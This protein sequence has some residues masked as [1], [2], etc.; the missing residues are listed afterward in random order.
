MTVLF[1]ED[2]HWADHATLDLVK[3]LVRRTIDRRTL[4]IFTLRDDE[5][6][7]VHPLR[8]VL[9]DLAGQR[10]V[11]RLKPAPDN[12]SRGYD[13]RQAGAERRRRAS[14]NGGQPLLCDGGYWTIGSAVPSTVRDAVL[15]RAA[16]LS[17][18]ARQLVGA[19]FPWSERAPT[20]PSWNGSIG[21]HQSKRKRPWERELV[22]KETGLGIRHELARM[23]ISN[24]SIRCSGV[25]FFVR[26]CVQPSKSP[27]SSR[28]RSSPIMPRGRAMQRPSFAMACRRPRRQ[29]PSVRI[30]RPRRTISA[31]LPSAR[32]GRPASGRA[33]SRLSAANGPSSIIFDEAIRTYRA[34]ISLRAEAGDT[35]REGAGSGQISPGRWCGAARTLP[36]MMRVSR[37]I[38][39]L[40]GSLLQRSLAERIGFR[41]T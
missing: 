3:F 40:G 17:R 24:R 36:P 30:A 4:L 10:S 5:I 26:F 20:T 11:S 16:R 1:I 25:V 31:C 13:D 34:A 35:L 32:T 33:L 14:E 9:G 6:G 18:G 39:V 28:Q 38:Q 19:S 15:A 27:T 7:A 29:P 23:A 12:R 21:Y 37:A 8:R 41:R 2:L 22:A